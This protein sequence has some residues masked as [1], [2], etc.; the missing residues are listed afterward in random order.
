[1]KGQELNDSLELPPIGE[2]VRAHLP[3]IFAHCESNPAE[4]SNLMDAD[5]TK[6]TFKV[7]F[8]FATESPEFEK[9]ERYWAKQHKVG[10]QVVRVTSEWHLRSYAPFVDY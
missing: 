10:G 6:H 2:F 4:L 9:P 3:A 1:M 5:Y 7:H 8:P